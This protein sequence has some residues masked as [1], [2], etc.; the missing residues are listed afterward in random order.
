[1]ACLAQ[2]IVRQ[3]EW[4]L[5]DALPAWED[6]STWSNYVIFSWLHAEQLLLVVVNYSPD[7]SQCYVRLAYPWLHSR[8]WRLED[9]LSPAVYVRH[10]TDL[11]GRGL[12][13]DLPAWGVH[14]FSFQ[15]ATE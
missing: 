5:L 7:P 12:Y 6:N 4:R 13:L 14:A 10:G 11:T 2:P 15:P 8:N 1:M 3:G 9:W